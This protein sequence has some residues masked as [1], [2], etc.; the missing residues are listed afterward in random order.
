MACETLSTFF[1]AQH[2]AHGVTFELGAIVEAFEGEGGHVTGVR[3]AGGRVIACDAV[4]IGVGL[5]RNDDLARDA[6][7]ECVDGIVV[8]EH[9]RTAD[10]DVFAIGDV[11]HRPIPHYERMFWLESVANALEQARQAAAAIAGR[12][13]AR[14]TR[15]PGTGRTNTI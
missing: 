11:T 1:T 10:P 14:R 15:S 8:D 6:G 3:L 13:A 9:A 4:L 2:E 5:V 7:L 12:P